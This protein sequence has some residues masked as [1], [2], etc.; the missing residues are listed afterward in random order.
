MKQRKVY[1][2]KNREKEPATLYFFKQNKSLK[3]YS[4]ILRQTTENK[5]NKKYKILKN[6]K[7]NFFTSFS[8]T[9]SKQTQH[10]KFSR[11]KLM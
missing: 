2:K 4:F 10:C 1:Y 5:S 8:R 9:K 7:K 6:Q 3:D 11:G